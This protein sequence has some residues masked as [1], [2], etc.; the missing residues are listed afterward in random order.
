MPMLS[1][2][3]S[4][5]DDSQSNSFGPLLQPGTDRHRPSLVMSTLVAAHAAF[6]DINS[7]SSPV[8][9]SDSDNDNVPGR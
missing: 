4:D 2:N 1:Y 6:T 3:H 5:R 7:G 8:G 9:P